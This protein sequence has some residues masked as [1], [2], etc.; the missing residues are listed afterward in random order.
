MEDIMKVGNIESWNFAN[1]T[2]F[3]NQKQNDVCNE[4]KGSDGTLLP[5]HLSA[6]D[7]MSIYSTDICRYIQIIFIING[8]RRYQNSNYDAM[9]TY[10]ISCSEI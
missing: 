4:V 6:V 9:S 7:S 2:K 10:P 5:P 3:W 1:H 8:N